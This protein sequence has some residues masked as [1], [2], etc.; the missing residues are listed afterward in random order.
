MESWPLLPHYPRPPLSAASAVGRRIT[1][2]G[3]PVTASTASGTWPVSATDTASLPNRHGRMISLVHKT[4][5]FL[6]GMLF[7]RRARR[8]E[9]LFSILAPLSAPDEEQRP[10]PHGFFL[11]R[12]RSVSR[13]VEDQP[14]RPAAAYR[15]GGRPSALVASTH[16][17]AA[18]VAEDISV[19]KPSSA[20]VV[21]GPPAHPAALSTS[22]SRGPE[23]T[24]GPCQSL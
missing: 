22:D 17:C 19:A 9:G 12:G 1:L 2:I 4:E 16:S 20:S 21:T 13:R 7:P 24:I 11:L 14:Q 5:R 10:R 23:K 15:M 8:R 6:S 18:S 3:A